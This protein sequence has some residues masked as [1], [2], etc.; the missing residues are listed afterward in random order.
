MKK[1]RLKELACC[2]V[3]LGPIGSVQ[4]GPIQTIP[5]RDAVRMTL[6]GL[7]A[8]TVLTG[9]L[10]GRLFDPPNDDAVSR[11]LT[12]GVAQTDVPNSDGWS[13]ELTIGYEPDKPFYAESRELAIGGQRTYTAHLHWGDVDPSIIPAHLTIEIRDPANGIPIETRT[14][15]VVNNT[16]TLTL[17]TR[18]VQLSFQTGKYLRYSPY[19]DCRAGDTTADL[20]PINGDID[21][22]NAI[23]VFDYGVLSDY[24][25]RNSG[26]PDWFDIGP[27]GFAPWD[28]DLDGDG[29][30]TVFD[31][32]ILSDNFDK[33]GDE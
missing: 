26:E 4:A 32:G 30:V 28:A 10:P 31:Y 3:L 22:D 18:I 19:A 2:V 13:R 27:N 16:F 12:I 8:A 6:I 7:R 29:A 33:N 1:K 9:V 14:V 17:P 23:T 24:F 21:N 15:D 5:T 11:E 25:D 20:T